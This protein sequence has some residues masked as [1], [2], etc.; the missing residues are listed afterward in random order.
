MYSKNE[1]LQRARQ[2][3]AEGWDLLP[4]RN[5]PIAV[6]GYIAFRKTGE[7]DDYDEEQEDIEWPLFDAPLESNEALVDTAAELV[8]WTQGKEDLQRCDNPM[9]RLVGFV[10]Y[11]PSQGRSE[12]RQIS[13]TNLKRGPDE[14][15][16]A[17]MALRNRLPS[18]QPEHLS[19]A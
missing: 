8:E 12:V 11:D 17:I 18:N 6:D 2:L 19:E 4:Y 1:A 7:G 15:K 10:Q 3:Q 14:A 5:A 9:K 16:D 13:L